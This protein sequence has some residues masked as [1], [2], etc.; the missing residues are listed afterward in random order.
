M[1]NDQL[2]VSHSMTLGE[3]FR[4]QMMRAWTP[5]H[6]LTVSFIIYFALAGSFL[7][8]GILLLVMSGSIVEIVFRYDDI[9]SGITYC[10]LN[11]TIQQNLT[12]PIFLYY[13]MT[14]MYQNHRKYLKS[15]SYEQLK[16]G[17]Y[18]SAGE[19]DDCE[20]VI[21]NKHIPR[22]TSLDGTVLDPEAPAF[23]C[24]LIAKTMFNDTFELY[25]NSIEI[26]ILENDIAYSTDKQKYKN[27]AV[28]STSLQW[29]DI[30][31]EHFMVWMRNGPLSKFRKLWGR[32]E[33]DISEGN[34]TM[35]IHN[36]TPS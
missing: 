2:N 13:Q 9:C 3:S 12:E 21:Y 33:D 14:E 30:E 27:L 17:E 4:Q 23:P 7:F 6:S 22:D 20:P 32:I 29:L 8:I 24:G 16:G 25:K 15:K 35:I 34:Y 26:E 31:D 10:P 36:R 18:L 1:K 19:L 5:F 28:N 11:I